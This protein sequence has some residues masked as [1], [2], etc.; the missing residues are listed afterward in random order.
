MTVKD[1]LSQRGIGKPTLAVSKSNCYTIIGADGQP[2]ATDIKIRWIILDKSLDNDQDFMVL[3]HNLAKE[4]IK[5]KSA[6]MNSHPVYDEDNGWGLQCPP[7][8]DTEEFDW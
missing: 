5:D 1:F 8:Y 4:V 7:T 6:L 3:S 2:Q